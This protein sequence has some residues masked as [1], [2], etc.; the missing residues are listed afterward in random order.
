[1]LTCSGSDSS[2][3]CPNLFSSSG[4][5]SLCIR[6][7]GGLDEDANQVLWAKGLSH[8]G[9]GAARRRSL[10]GSG[11]W[12]GGRRKVET[13]ALCKTITREEFERRGCVLR[14]III[15]STSLFLVTKGYHINS[16]YGRRT[17]YST[18]DNRDFSNKTKQ[19]SLLVMFNIHK[20][21]VIAASIQGNSFMY[22]VLPSCESILPVDMFKIQVEYAW[23]RVV[24]GRRNLASSISNL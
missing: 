7:G 10:V 14:N 19:L 15:A 11:N 1:M 5:R 18:R 21:D 22:L 13:V 16:M 2:F 23:N 20:T 6:G 12:N 9:A 4:S 3:C 8:A 17:T 24:R